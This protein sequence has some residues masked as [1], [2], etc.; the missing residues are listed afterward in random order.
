MVKVAFV[1]CWKVIVAEQDWLT[2]TRKSDAGIQFVMEG[3][4]AV[5]GLVGGFIAALT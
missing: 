2:A 4:L 1:N 3:V 5:I